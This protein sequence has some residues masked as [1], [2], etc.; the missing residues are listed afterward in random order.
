MCAVQTHHN[1]DNHVLSA[2]DF[3]PVLAAG[4]LCLFTCTVSIL[5]VLSMH[6]GVEYYSILLHILIYTFDVTNGK[7]AVSIIYTLSFLDIYFLYGHRSVSMKS[8]LH[9]DCDYAP[10]RA[11]KNA[12]SVNWTP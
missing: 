3:D 5:L 6:S 7:T 9:W 11:L 4:T 1:S 8:R 10:Q 2:L 12:D